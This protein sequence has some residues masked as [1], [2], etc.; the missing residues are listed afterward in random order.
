MTFETLARTDLAPGVGWRRLATEPA[1]PDVVRHRPGAWALAV[2]AVCIGACMGQLDASIVTL[3]LPSLQHQLGAGLDAVTWVALAYLVV[4]IGSVTAVGRFSD[5]VGRKVVYLYGFAIFTVGSALCALAPNVDVL[6]C[7]RV[8]QAVGAACL[9]AN[10]VAIVALA[11]PPRALGRA[12]GLQGTAQA[13]GLALGPTVGG[14]LLALGGWRLIF[15]VNVPLG[16]LG[17]AAGWLFIPRS[18]H[19]AP[20]KRFDWLGLGL[21][22]PAVVGVLLALSFGARLGWTSARVLGLVLGSGGLLAAF[23]MRQR[24]TPAPLVDPVLLR[25]RPLR[26]GLVAGFL[27]AAV[28][29]GVLFATPFLLLGPLGLGPAA[30][31]LCLTALPVALALTAPFAGRMADRSATGRLTL[32]GML[33]A[34]AALLVLAGLAAGI[35]PAGLVA[36]L[37]VVGVGLGLFLSPNSAA[38]MARVPPSVTGLASGLVNMARGL[39][40]AVGLAGAGLVF[41]LVGGGAHHPPFD[42]VR[43]SFAVTAAGM[44]LA[45]VAAGL[46]GWRGSVEGAGRI[47]TPGLDAGI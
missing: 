12:L 16:I 3:A 39:G 43:L 41:A 11:A 19:L 35:G 20:R 15:W 36:G 31:G 14:L 7:C 46:L 10:S 30:A 38:V 8:L 40:T 45:A 37:V 23:V 4:L 29:F 22:F 13:V 2:G 33:V 9:Q 34:A 25:L 47:R 28:L 42:A 21:F 5:M 44:A 24:R 18:R 26:D 6:I 32:A 17:L 27:S 1:R